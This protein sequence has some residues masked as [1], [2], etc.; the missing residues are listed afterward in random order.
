GSSRPAGPGGR[1]PGGPGAG[2]ARNGEAFERDL[3]GDILPFVEGNYR[4]R[5]EPASNAIAALST[6]GGQALTIGLNP[7]DRFGW[8]GGFS[9]AVFNPETALGSA[10]K[11]PKATDAALAVIWIACGKNDF[12]IENNKQLDSFL[13]EK[14]IH[15]EFLITEGNHSWPVWRRYLAEFAPLLFVEKP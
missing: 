2:M 10:L 3:L 11:D 12:L 15:H 14:S 1:G 6:G 8:V 9:S 7:F 13:K 4:V 5:T